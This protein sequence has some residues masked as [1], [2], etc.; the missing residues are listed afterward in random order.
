[1][2]PAERNLFTSVIT[3]LVN[4]PGDPNPYG[5]M[6]DHHKAMNHRMH[7]VMGGMTD[8]IGRQRFLSWHRIYL[9]KVEKMGQAINSSFFIPYWDWT[10]QAQVPPWLANFKPTIKVT[11][12]N[13]TVM[14]NPPAAAPNNTLPK[15]A[16]VAFTKGRSTYTAFTRALEEGFGL[17]LAAGAAGM[18]N[19]V[20]VWCN[21]T[22]SFVPQ[23]PADPLFWLHHANIDRIWA[24]WQVTHPALGPSLTGAFKTMDPWPETV[25]QAKSLAS[26]GYSY[27]P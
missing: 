13:I 16:Q 3:R 5:I 20:H 17:S 15:A 1:M 27:G 6:V 26:L 24:E 12:A 23:A 14:R 22:M 7:G 9:V 4:A 18:H 2:T 8:P 21:G 11:G 19:L 10:T 25:T